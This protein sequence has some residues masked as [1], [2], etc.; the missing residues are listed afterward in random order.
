MKNV[1]VTG[2]AGQLGNS[3]RDIA[4]LYP[5]LLF[6]WIDIADLDITNETAL[7]AFIKAGKPEVIINCAA[8]TAVDKA[9]Q[10][11]EKAFLINAGAVKNLAALSKAKGIFLIHISTDYVFD[12]TGNKPYTES[13]LPNPVSV[14]AKS[15][16]AGELAVLESGCKAIIL[17]TSWLYSEYGNNFL[18]TIKRLAGEREELKV[19]SDQIGTPTYSGD[20]AKVIL[21]IIAKHPVPDKPE[22]YHYSNGGIISW[23]EFAKAIVEESGSKCRVLPI[24]TTDYPLPAAR[25]MYS[26]MCKEKIKNAFGITIPVWEAS[27]KICLANMK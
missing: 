2:S 16:Y 9:E 7:S 4:D 13:D 24:P 1:L 14:Y 26:A 6:T 8:Y 25:P 12:G 3:L 15:K 20:L 27:L 22:I 19:V 11:K 10:E 23:Y 5:G 18:K 21:D 17:R